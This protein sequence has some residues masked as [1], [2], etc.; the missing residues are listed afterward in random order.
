MSSKWEKLN[1]IAS[2]TPRKSIAPFSS[3]FYYLDLIQVRRRAAS[4]SNSSA[5]SASYQL[6]MDFTCYPAYYS[7]GTSQCEVPGT[8]RPRIIRHQSKVAWLGKN[9]RKKMICKTGERRQ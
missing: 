1:W 7:Y 2:V 8:L 3:S 5:A 4:S 9:I 6:V